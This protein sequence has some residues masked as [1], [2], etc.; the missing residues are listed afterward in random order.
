MGISLFKKK[1]LIPL[2]RTQRRK[3][4]NS[5]EGRNTQPLI[6]TWKICDWWQSFKCANDLKKK[7]KERRKRKRK[8]WNANYSWI[9]NHNLPLTQISLLSYGGEEKAARKKSIFEIP[10]TAVLNCRT[11]RKEGRKEQD[12]EGR[13]MAGRD[14][15]WFS[16]CCGGWY[17]ILTENGRQNK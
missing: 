7:R 12:R 6:H 11:R 8:T 10:T 5:F 13:N 4:Y 9:Y 17:M 14:I 15:L 16:G 1:N 2:S 3:S